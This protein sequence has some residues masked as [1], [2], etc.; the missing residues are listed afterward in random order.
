MT[1]VEDPRPGSR[2]GT[3]ILSADDVLV[4][5]IGL[6]LAGAGLPEAAISPDGHAA[7]TGFV[8]ARVVRAAYPHAA[9]TWFEDGGPTGDPGGPAGGLRDCERA[10]SRAGFHTEYRADSTGGYLLACRKRRF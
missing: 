2:G 4:A 5:A 10:L 1:V 8:A 6:V 3:R 9:V 7:G